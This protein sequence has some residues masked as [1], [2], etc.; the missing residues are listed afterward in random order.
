MIRLPVA[1][2]APILL[3]PSYISM[4]QHYRHA[5]AHVEQADQ[6]INQASGP[7]DLTLGEVKLEEAAKNLDALPVWFLGYSPQYTFWYG[8]QFTLDEFRTARANV[9]RMEATLFQEKQAQIQ[10]TQAE[11]AI[12]VAKQQYQQAKTVAERT[13]EI[14]AWQAALDI[15]QQ[16]PPETLAGRV[17]QTKLVAFTR[18]YEK[19]ASLAIGSAR[20][21]TLIEAAQE[22][23]KAGTQVSLKPPNTAASWNQAASLWQKAI[24][25]LEAIPVE[26][27]GYASA[28]KLLATYQTNLGTVQTHLQAEQAA[29]EVLQQAQTSSQDLVASGSSMDRNQIIAQ[30][31]GIMDQ[32]ETIPPGTTAYSEA[33]NLMGSAQ[34]KLQQ[35]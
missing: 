15:L 1:R 30:L 23:A 35:L 21:G 6:L 28:Q 34:E 10:L 22:F 20:S 4:D 7:G 5:I 8:W 33:Q 16:I 14:A 13:P 9:G 24:E 31:Q 18:D 25:R 2:T 17:A 19:V 27:P 11:Q 26:D 3:L 29:V 12:K 32:L